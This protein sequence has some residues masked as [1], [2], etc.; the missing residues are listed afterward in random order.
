VPNHRKDIDLKAFLCAILATLGNRASFQRAELLLVLAE[1]GPAT[2]SKLGLELQA[3]RSTVWDELQWLLGATPSTGRPALILER[4]VS[5][6]RTALAYELTPAGEAI[7][8]EWLRQAKS[9]AAG[10]TQ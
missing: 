4:R 10:A 1:T 8:G 3:P 2:I 6:S 9:A 5:P 7:V